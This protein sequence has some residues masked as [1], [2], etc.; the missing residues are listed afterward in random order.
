[1]STHASTP[2]EEEML[3]R[4][5]RLPVVDTHEHM[6]TEASFVAGEYD[7]THLMC[8]TG[9][10]IGLAGLSAEPWGGAQFAVWEG[11][12]IDAKWRRMAPY[13]P[14]VRQGAFGRAY[15]L[16]LKRFFDVDD[17]DSRTVHLVSERIAEYQRKGIFDEYLH[18]R[19]GIRVMLL[20]YGHMPVP[21]PEP[22]HFATVY[23]FSDLAGAFSAEEA[24]DCLGE[25]LPAEAGDFL[26]LVRG[27]VDTAAANGAVSLKIGW[28]GRRRPLDFVAHEPADVQESYT[29]L[30]E[31]ADGDWTDPDTALRLKPFQ[32]ASFWAVFEK[33]G[34]LGLPVQIHSGLEFQQP[35]D[36]RPTCLIPSLNR[37]PETKFV[38]FH[39]SYPYMAELT[40]L[41]KGFPNVYLDLAW[42]HLLSRY[43]AR[44]WLA[45][46]LDVLPHNKIFAFGGD[47]VLFFNVCA[48]LELARENV[49]AVLAQRVA[50]GLCDVDEATQTARA[51]F[52]DNPWQTFRL[53]NW[54]GRRG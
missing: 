47:V 33:A 6:A 22:E 2:I 48:C 38:I 51:L 43:Q 29:F 45:E 49:A 32:D 18:G 35:W 20:V 40:G 1:M 30:R 19:Y 44:A 36:G 16:I 42:F 21:A 23:H 46:W 10:D 11:D 4:I 13:W 3:E 14:H 41:A 7:F 27:C 31:R 28:P 54:A 24:R 50:D 5:S 26:E 15:R 52:H 37:F 9:L 12:S 39:G 34:E 17:L 8:Y 53:E 25:D